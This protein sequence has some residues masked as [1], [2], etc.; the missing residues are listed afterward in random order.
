[1]TKQHSSLDDIRAQVEACHRCPLADGRTQTVFGAGNEHARVLIIGEAPGKNEDLQGEPFVGSAGKYLN[2]L[3][4]VAGLERKDVFIANVLKCRPPS[5]R[6][7]RAE[8]IELCAPYLREQTRAI[9]PEFIVTLGNFSTKFI[10]KTDI[11]ITLL[12]GSLQQAGK[13]KVFPIFHPAAALYDGSKR[14][15]LENDFATLGE[16]LRANDAAKACASDAAKA[17]VSDAM[18][19]NAAAEATPG[20]QAAADASD[21]TQ[22]RAD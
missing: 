19:A 20:S 17:R 15:A 18:Q 10:L 6:N 2:E 16:L 4:A 7:P 13:F 22:H 9:D 5:N 12:H 21:Q 3:L 1:M 14:V 11:G 8:E